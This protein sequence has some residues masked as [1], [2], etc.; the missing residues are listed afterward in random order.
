MAINHIILSGIFVK[1]SG[2]SSR[3]EQ[4]KPATDMV[5]HN[6][7]VP[8][9]DQRST[10][11]SL[12]RQ[13]IITYNLQ[14]NVFIRANRMAVQ[15]LMI[16]AW[17][18]RHHGIGHAITPNT[19]KAMFRAA[20]AKSITTKHN[21]SSFKISQVDGLQP[22][23]FKAGIPIAQKTNRKNPTIMEAMPIRPTIQQTGQKS[24]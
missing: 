11:P 1:R 17:I 13:V 21:N 2:I 20:I 18:T 12:Q 9:F 19:T 7:Q 8:N 23:I 15:A 14:F 10:L 4:T 22:L 24:A 5:I 16:A 3:H 6:R